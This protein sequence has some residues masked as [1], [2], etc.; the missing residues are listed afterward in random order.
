MFSH[1]KMSQTLECAFKI[2]ALLVYFEPR[3][4]P[5]QS[6]MDQKYIVKVY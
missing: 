6:S 4:E 2:M 1:Q 5:L 3:P